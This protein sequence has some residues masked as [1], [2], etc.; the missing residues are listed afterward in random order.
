LNAS[1]RKFGGHCG[2]TSSA[3]CTILRKKEKMV[4]LQADMQWKGAKKFVAP[5]VW[6]KL[7]YLDNGF[8]SSIF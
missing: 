8:Y 7:A 3:L 1:H 5:T 6:N 2:F 4:A